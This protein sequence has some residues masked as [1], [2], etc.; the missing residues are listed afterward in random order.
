MFT[1]KNLRKNYVSKS[2]VSRALQDISFKLPDVGMCF[3]VGKSGSGKSTLLNL[4]TGMDKQSEGTIKLSDRI[5]TDFSQKK[6]DDY[7]NGMIGYIF[8]EF[9]LL[10]DL[11]VLQNIV[12][13][14]E[15]QKQKPDMVVV[16]NLLKQIVLNLSFSTRKI[17]QLSGGQKQRIAIARALI[18]NPKIII[19]DEPTGNLDSQ[20]TTQ[21]FDLLKELAQNKLII[22]VSH[23]MESSYKYA[24][25]IISL[26]DGKIESDLQCLP[27][28]KISKKDK[29]IFKEG[30]VVTAD[31][32]KTY[33]EQLQKNPLEE[34]FISTDEKVSYCLLKFLLIL[35][36]LVFLL[37]LLLKQLFKVSRARNFFFF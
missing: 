12:L 20:T 6:L 35:F 26:K 17:N 1:I 18:K 16:E 8:Q 22:V 19:A 24:G 34:N 15:L 36:H 3:I 4:L 14:L 27:E 11:N 29:Q 31:M 5:I 23:D 28:N 7:L 33:Q 32:M 37:N 25:R 21:V 10:E 2:V 30:Q 9:N 13:H